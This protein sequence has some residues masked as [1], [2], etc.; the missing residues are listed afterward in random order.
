MVENAA[1]DELRVRREIRSRPHPECGLCGT[2]GEMLY[3]NLTDRLFGAPGEWNLKRCPDPGCGLVW[4]DPMPLE[5]DIGIAYETYFTH[6]PKDGQTPAA[7]FSARRRIA[8]TCRSAYRAWRY[9]Y[10][11]DTGKPLRWLFALPIVLAQIGRNGLDIPLQYLAVPDK[12]RVLDVGCGDGSVLELARELGWRTEG[13]DFDPQAVE[14]AR[15]KGL[16]V[17]LG[18]L[19]DQH[20]P[21]ES[22]DLVLMSH[23]IEHLHDPLGTLREVERV[24]RPAGR[25]VITTPNLESQGYRHFGSDWVHLDPPR[26]L[27]LFKDVSLCILAEK[28]GFRVKR[29]ASS[30]R[31]TSFSFVASRSI[32]R[33]GRV[34]Q[35]RWPTSVQRI[36]GWGG[37]ALQLLVRVFSA[38]AGDELLLEAAK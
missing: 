19:A 1:V 15:G 3:T 24:L 25:L 9:N 30:L 4:L 17:K 12:G 33:T 8:E 7:R 16:S 29:S 35:L 31:M 37:S 32:A 26:H 10:G 28:A 20:Y 21:D 6:A 23:V 22:F 5:E 13:M 34:G 2:R 27:N 36:Y 14:N 38:F 11:P 18:T